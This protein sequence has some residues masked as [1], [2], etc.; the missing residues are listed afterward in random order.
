MVKAPKELI[1]DLKVIFRK[2]DIS[3]AVDDQYD[4][5]DNYAGQSVEIRSNRMVDGALPIYIDD[6]EALARL[7]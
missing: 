7:L 2:Y 5:E 4:G 3:L 6:M 1:E